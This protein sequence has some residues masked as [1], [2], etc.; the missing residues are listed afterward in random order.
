MKTIVYIVSDTLRFNIAG[1]VAILEAGL[2]VSVMSQ[3]LR[4]IAASYITKPMMVSPSCLIL[5]LAWYW[6]AE[7]CRQLPSVWQMLCARAWTSTAIAA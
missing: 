7:N 4:T 5:K 2:A 1:I 3:K 6:V